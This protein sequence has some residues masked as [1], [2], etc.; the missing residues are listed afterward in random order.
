MK[1]VVYDTGVLI[2]ADRAER[3]VWAEHRVRLE[4]GY[5]PLVPAPVVAQASRSSKQVALRRFLRGCDTVAFDEVAAHRA[6]ALLGKSRTK[7][8]VDAAVALVAI[9]HHADIVSDDTGDLH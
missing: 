8:V 4:A 1:A 2:A 9:E 6:G 5:V 3:R 7:D